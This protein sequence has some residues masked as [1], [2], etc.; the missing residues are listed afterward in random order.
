MIAHGRLYDELSQC[1][2]NRLTSHGKA[3]VYCL[4]KLTDRQQELLERLEMTHLVSNAVINEL[5][6]KAAKVS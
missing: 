4:T 5:R 1:N 6:S 3:D 2:L